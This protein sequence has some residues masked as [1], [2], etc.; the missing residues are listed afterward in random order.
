ME[1]MLPPS[2]YTPRH[3]NYALVSVRHVARQRAEADIRALWKVGVDLKASSPFVPTLGVKLELRRVSSASCFHCTCLQ[4]FTL[5]ISDP[6][7]C[8]NITPPEVFLQRLV[9]SCTYYS[10]SK[11]RARV[12]RYRGH[13]R[14]PSFHHPAWQSRAAIG[15]HDASWR[16]C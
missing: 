15:T 6:G 14:T 16:S 5:D 10:Q 1:T 4:H 8:S 7:F 11:Q 13:G 2:V 12:P 9:G 3:L